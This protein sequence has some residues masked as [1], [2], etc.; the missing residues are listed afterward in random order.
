MQSHS[1]A[2]EFYFKI[3][4]NRPKINVNLFGARIHLQLVGQH[5]WLIVSLGSHASRSSYSKWGSV[6]NDGVLKSHKIITGNKFRFGQADSAARSAD[7]K[8]A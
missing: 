2:V 8:Y 7:T 4:Q 1:V 5:K 3:L 6:A